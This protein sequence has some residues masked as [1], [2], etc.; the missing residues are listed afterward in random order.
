MTG[1][2]GHEFKEGCENATTKLLQSEEK[3]NIGSKSKGN[4]ESLNNIYLI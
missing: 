1:Q 4:Y 2:E 3:I